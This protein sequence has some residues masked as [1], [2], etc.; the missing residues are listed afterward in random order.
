[1]SN[2][3]SSKKRTSS[4]AR[5]SKSSGSKSGSSKASP[6]KAGSGKGG[7]GTGRIEPLV[8]VGPGARRHAARSAGIAP[9]TGERRDARGDRRTA[10]RVPR[11]RVDRCGD[12]ARTRHV[13]RPRRPAGRR[14]VETVFGWLAGLGR[15]ALPVVL[16]A[17]GVSLVRRGHTSS[18]LRLGV[19]WAL[20][21]LSSLGL[22]H[23]FRGPTISRPTSIS[24]NPPAGGSGRSWPSPSRRSSVRSA[25]R[26][27]SWSCSSAACCSSPGRRC[28]RWR[29]TPGASSPRSRTRSD[30]GPNP[31]SA[32]SPR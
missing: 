25:P 5:S 27:S 7:S 17:I 11:T 3:G 1:M 16:A 22:L 30:G 8:V 32:T 4:T 26:W 10:A 31:A 24:S 6:S 14:G 13:L 9:N 19:G 29:R 15:Y 23:V 20:V 2:W 21:A 18:P 12:P 28:G